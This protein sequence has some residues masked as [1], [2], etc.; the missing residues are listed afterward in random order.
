[1]SG[2]VRCGIGMLVCLCMICGRVY[3]DELLVGGGYGEQVGRNGIGQDNAV[4]DILYDFSD[5]DWRNWRVTLGLGASWLWND[6]DEHEVFIGSLVPTF[7][8]FLAESE[9]MDFYVFVSTGFSY[10][11][12][13]SLG[14]QLLGGYF[15]FNDFF[16]LGAYM[17]P[18]Q[19]WSVNVC[20]R[21]I[22]NA[23][24]FDPNEGID[25]PFYL[26][27]GHRF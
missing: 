27:V 6:F 9:S 1:M 25:I 4:V 14:Q 15:A 20:W 26:M 24:L 23:G 16:G 11:T 19:D 3:G 12:E 10:M 21:H 18:E 22:S 5:V 2:R 8:Y 13:P 7:R 17:G